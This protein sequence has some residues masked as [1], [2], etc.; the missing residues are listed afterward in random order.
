[1]K[2]HYTDFVMSTQTY[3]YTHTVIRQKKK[4]IL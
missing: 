1:M 4:R 3:E 2:T